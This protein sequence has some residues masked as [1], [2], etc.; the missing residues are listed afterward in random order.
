M[1]MASRKALNELIASFC[2]LSS[3]VL[4]GTS[5]R[6]INQQRDLVSFAC[7]NTLYV[8][9][10]LSSLRS[11]P[12]NETSDLRGL[13]SIALNL[14]IAHGEETKEEYAD[15]VQNLEDSVHALR[16]RYYDKV[17]TLVSAAMTDSD[18]CEDCFGETEERESSL[19]E[20]NQYFHKLCSNFL[21]IT[22]LHF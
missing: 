3:F 7:N 2:L 15:A 16:I 17:N 13:A 18:T 19:T 1:K 8:E 6:Q 9:E 20:R 4:L 22:N 11:E 5:T 12:L 10:C 21:S 14:S